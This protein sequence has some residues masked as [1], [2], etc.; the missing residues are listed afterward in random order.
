MSLVAV[1]EFGHACV[2]HLSGP[3]TWQAFWAPHLV[4][5]PNPIV[6]IHYSFMLISGFLGTKA[7]WVI[8]SL[9]FNQYAPG[10][11]WGWLVVFS[12]VINTVKHHVRTKKT[13]LLILWLLNFYWVRSR[14]I[15]VCVFFNY[16]SFATF[17]FTVVIYSWS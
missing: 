15:K 11:A 6:H 13:I 4:I 8:V 17:K 16:I 14:W 1:G 7:K 5:I 3:P 9:F 12:Y 10:V 2:M